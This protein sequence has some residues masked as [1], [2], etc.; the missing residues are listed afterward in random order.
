MAISNPIPFTPSPRFD[1]VARELELEPL[2]FWFNTAAADE[3]ARLR[4]RIEMAASL[5]A[6]AAKLEQPAALD[7][8]A[9]ALKFKCWHDL[10]E[11]LKQVWGLA[12]NPPDG[13]HPPLPPRWLD[14]LSEAP[15][16]MIDA[17][18][19]VTLPAPQRA[20]LEALGRTLAMLCDVPTQ[21]VLDGVCAALCGGPSW[22]E[23]IGRSPYTASLPLYAF[24]APDLQP[25]EVGGYFEESPACQEL[26][27]RLDEQWQGWDHFPKA[28]KRLA[29]AW[30]EQVIEA[31]PGFLEGGL[32]L[33]T[34]Q[35][36]YSG[37]AEPSIRRRERLIQCS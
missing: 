6:K 27:D 32:A 18:G 36:A 4:A 34:M 26:V 16:L 10:D 35:H 20:A 23:V 8:V 11:H 19:D 24:I 21:L 12:R 29:R 22:A 9:Q 28:R 2:T 15:I 3:T 33:A 30:V 25:D 13:V 7:A 31:Q 17:P 1:R 5:L 37:S 14:A